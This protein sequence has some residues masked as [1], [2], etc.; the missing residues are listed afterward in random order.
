[1]IGQRNNR[2]S[3]RE[4]TEQRSTRLRGNLCLCLKLLPRHR[5]VQLTEVQVPK[6]LHPRC[7]SKV[8]QVQGGHLVCHAHHFPLALTTEGS[9]L[10]PGFTHDQW[11]EKVSY[12]WYDQKIWKVESA[13]YDLKFPGSISISHEF[14]DPKVKNWTTFASA[15]GKS[16]WIAK[17]CWKNCVCNKHG[18]L[19][20]Q[21]Q[22]VSIYLQ[23]MCLVSLRK[24]TLPLQHVSS[25]GLRSNHSAALFEPR[26]WYLAIIN[27]SNFQSPGTCA[28]I[29]P[30]SATVNEESGKPADVIMIK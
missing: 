1:M 9:E 11:A 12:L 17:S 18:E 27:C 13:T 29:H 15:C 10:L 26:W 6:A 23:P 8:H 14:T 7:A 2:K 3:S 19:M 28:S 20:K 30:R 4:T 25:F 5:L 24:P 21:W 16:M 22:C